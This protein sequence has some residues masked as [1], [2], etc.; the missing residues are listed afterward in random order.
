MWCWHILP[1]KISAIWCIQECFPALRL[2]SPETN[3]VQ[4][5]V[6]GNARGHHSYLI[7]TI[8]KFTIFLLRDLIHFSASEAF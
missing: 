8:F 2:S 4:C 1:V 3:N 5:Y 6:I 7:D